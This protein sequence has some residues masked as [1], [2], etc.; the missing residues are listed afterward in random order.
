MFRRRGGSQMSKRA[1]R[2]PYPV[3]KFFADVSIIIAAVMFI[4]CFVGMMVMAIR[5]ER[6]LAIGL[7]AAS[8]PLALIWAFHGES[9]A[10]LLATERHMQVTAEQAEKT[11]Q[12]LEL[13]LRSQQTTSPKPADS[14]PEETRPAE[15]R[16]LHI[17]EAGHS[18]TAT[19]AR[20]VSATP[21]DRLGH[22]VA[23]RH[24]TCPAC[25]TEFQVTP[26][27]LGK[28]VRCGKCQARFVVEG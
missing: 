17:Q 1:R 22:V 28:P 16:D 8:I 13:I 10:L 11:N 7:G 3:I 26:E 20:G 25:G 15:F 6:V 21:A 19:T 9:L 24:V 14:Q 12:L 5:G 2:N 4:A 18:P 23:S 27:F